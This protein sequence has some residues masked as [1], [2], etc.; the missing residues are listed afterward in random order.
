M[1][2]LNDKTDDE[3]L[4]LA[5]TW[6]QSLILSEYS[7]PPSIV[8]VYRK[9]DQLSL[10]PDAL[11]WDGVDALYL[12]SAKLVQD[13]QSVFSISDYDELLVNRKR[14]PARIVG[15]GDGMIFTDEDGQDEIVD[16][17][18]AVYYDVNWWKPI[19][20]DLKKTA[21]ANGATLDLDEE[22]YGLPELSLSINRTNDNLLA[23]YMNIVR[24]STGYHMI[25]STD[26]DFMSF[27]GFDT[28][29]LNF[30]DDDVANRMNIAFKNVIR[31]I[32]ENTKLN[33]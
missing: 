15:G 23:M 27:N 22:T 13:G 25:F 20:R 30:N 14:L 32:I 4:Q 2:V 19:V 16:L 24:S 1:E 18:T 17:I 28:M 33:S 29:R 12:K 11:G 21:E 31:P 26:Y 9:D 8:T 7:Y 3:L 6:D 5:S 10:D